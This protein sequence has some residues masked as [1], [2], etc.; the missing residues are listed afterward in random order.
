MWS[1][2]HYNITVPNNQQSAW[3]KSKTS[4]KTINIF[5]KLKMLSL[6]F[7]FSLTTKISESNINRESP[8]A[9][10][11]GSSLEWVWNV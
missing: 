9:V 1:I 2:W 3:L 4:L 11:V 10:G 7:S 8:A 5:L 6:N